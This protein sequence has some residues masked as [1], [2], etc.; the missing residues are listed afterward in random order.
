[1]EKK[2][3]VPYVSIVFT[4][5]DMMHETKI[6]GIYDSEKEAIDGLIKHVI[7]NCEYFDLEY[8]KKFNPD[9]GLMYMDLVEKKK[10][11]DIEKLIDR[12]KNEDDGWYFEHL[13]KNK[14]HSGRI[15]NWYYDIQEV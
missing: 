2:K 10:E 13:M 15:I 9:G 11:E 8:E 3:F 5:E 1:M 12:F 7:L 6:V 14:Y 4:G